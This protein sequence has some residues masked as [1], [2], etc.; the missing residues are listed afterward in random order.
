MLV[1]NQVQAEPVTQM[2]KEIKAE[3]LGTDSSQPAY[4]ESLKII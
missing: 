2:S 3:L 1:I 4:L